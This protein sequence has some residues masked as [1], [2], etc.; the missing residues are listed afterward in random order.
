MSNA[1]GLP[2]PTAEQAI[3][4]VSKKTKAS[5]Y[6]P[7]E[8]HKGLRAL[9]ELCGLFGYDIT[10]IRFGSREDGKEYLWSEWV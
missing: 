6:L 8:L 1:S 9:R 2:D 3:A 7:K 5:R 10:E 4:N